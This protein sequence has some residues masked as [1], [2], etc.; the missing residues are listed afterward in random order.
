MICKKNLSAFCLGFVS[1][2]V[3]LGVDVGKADYG[4]AT[5]E[6]ISAYN[7]VKRCAKDDAIL[8][9]GK[10]GPIG[11]T[12]Y[13]IRHVLEHCQD[14][15]RSDKDRHGLFTDVPEHQNWAKLAA[16]I[17]RVRDKKRIGINGDLYDIFWEC[18][19]QTGREKVTLFPV[20]KADR[21]L[22]GRGRG[23]KDGGRPYYGYQLVV[24]KVGRERGMVTFYP[25]YPFY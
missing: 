14:E 11:Y 15:E 13:G 16:C 19:E 3:L 21:R 8:L 10:W 22:T 20:K 7:T 23:K 12:V 17:Y 1:T 5:D 25:C 18:D 2:V 24:E 9:Y 6:L 4:S